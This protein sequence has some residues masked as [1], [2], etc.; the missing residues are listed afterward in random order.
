MRDLWVWLHW[1]QS[2]NGTYR[3]KRRRRSRWKPRSRE[4][5]RNRSG[6]KRDKGERGSDGSVRE[7]LEHVVDVEHTL[8]GL[9]GL[10]NTVHSLTEG[11]DFACISFSCIARRAVFISRLDLNGDWIK[12]GNCTGLRINFDTMF[13]HPPDQTVRNES[14][15]RKVMARI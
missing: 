4:Y 1:S 7:V 3:G 9:M 12:S 10:Q 5:K 13:L 15:Q 8:K 11:N 2:T 6:L 14:L